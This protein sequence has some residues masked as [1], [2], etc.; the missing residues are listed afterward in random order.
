MRAWV[1]VVAAGCGRIGFGSETSHDATASDV[2]AIGHDED[3]DGVA[4]TTDN[5]P[6][7]PNT[8]QLDTDGDGVGDACD[9]EPTNPRQ[10]IAKFSSFVTAD[11][12]YCLDVGWSA[13]PDALAYDGNGQ[14]TLIAFGSYV[15][16]DV[17][18][19][20][21]I[22]GPMGPEGRQIALQLNMDAVTPYY[23]GEYFETSPTTTH[24]NIME[25]DGT[26]FI[27]INSTPVAGAIHSGALTF[28]LQASASA[29]TFT[30][31]SGWPGE[32]YQVSGGTP[33]YTTADILLLVVNDVALQLDSVMIVATN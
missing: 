8:D 18:M 5:C 1:L 6:N 20:F 10:S 22:I 32:P 33:A 24:T 16:T 26:N 4:D 29:Q 15:E 9:R 30:L 25:Y 23:Y 12:S 21:E 2:A 3:A 19:Q 13:V 14:H 11:P 7:V 28:H 27:A 17:W 31:T